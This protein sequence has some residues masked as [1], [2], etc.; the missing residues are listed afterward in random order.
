MSKQ[1]ISLSYAPTVGVTPGQ[2]VSPLGQAIRFGKMLFVSGQGAVDPANGAVVKGDIAT[3]TIMTLDNV[4]S[5]LEAAGATLKNVVNMRV[6]LRDIADFP[7]FNEIFCEYLEG[8]NITWTCIGDVPNRSG[9]NV[10]IDCIAM[11]D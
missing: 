4:T 6:N 5:V 10:Q 8:E 11:F 2:I 3:Q 1:I 7:R 9:V